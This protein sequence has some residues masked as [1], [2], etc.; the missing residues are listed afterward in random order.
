MIDVT[1][2]HLEF[3]A[4]LAR[5]AVDLVETSVDARLIVLLRGGAASKSTSVELREKHGNLMVAVAVVC[6]G[7]DRFVEAVDCSYYAG[8]RQAA[9][10]IECLELLSVTTV[11]VVAEGTW[12]SAQ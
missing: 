11:T 5:E 12:L 4:V 1:A 3:D 7:L 8:R 10:L 6:E 9:V 2:A